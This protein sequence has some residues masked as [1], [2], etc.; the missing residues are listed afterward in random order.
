MSTNRKKTARKAVSYP[1][2]RCRCSCSLFGHGFGSQLAPEPGSLSYH[3]SELSSS[4]HT[5]DLV[6]EAECENDVALF[7]LSVELWRQWCASVTELRLDLSLAFAAS[8]S[9]VDVR[10]TALAFW[11]GVLKQ[12]RQCDSSEKKVTRCSGGL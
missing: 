10:A 8:T 7:A 12:T 3:R 1:L 11:S 4:T 6:R 5:C 2:S 9:G